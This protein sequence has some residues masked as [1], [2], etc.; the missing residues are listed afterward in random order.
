LAMEIKTSWV[1]A[2]TI[3]DNSS[4]IIID[5]MIPTY[6]KNST[7]TNW[8]INGQVKAKLAMIGMHVVGSTAGHPEMVWS[9]FEH[10]NNAPN[11]E[12]TYLDKNSVVKT[13]RADGGKEWLLNSDSEDGTYNVSH[14]NF[15]GDSIIAA[16]CGAPPKNTISPSNTK[17]TKPWGFANG[18]VPNPE[19]ATVA[20]ANSQVIS[21][22]NSVLGMLKGNDIRK[23][24][25]FI[26]STWTSGGAAPDGTSYACF[27]E[28]NTNPGTAIGGSQLANS[29]METYIQNGDAYAE[30]G[31]CFTCHS[32][33]KPTL[34]PDYISHVFNDL[35]P[36]YT[37]APDGK[38]FNKVINHSRPEKM[39]PVNK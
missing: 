18:G 4:Y 20:E 6:A 13:R 21:I 7:N 26:G 17:R 31:S 1:D 36:L 5:A 8:T 37:T 24:Y 29:T 2:S 9:T 22:N 19:N 3:K 39:H 33:S 15:E 35:K 25:L 12:Y 28:L 30:Q 34:S 32:A 27:N 16:F 14:M 11:L 23:N 38:F 10:R